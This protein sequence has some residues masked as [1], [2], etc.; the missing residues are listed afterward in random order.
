MSDLHA[1]W[2]DVLGKSATMVDHHA[3]LDVDATT[4]DRIIDGAH[5]IRLPA[6]AEKLDPAVWAKESFNMA[7]RDTY[8]IKPFV[9]QNS[10]GD[11]ILKI[12][13]TEDYHTTAVKDA[14]RR[15]RIA[16]HRLAL[17]LK[18]IL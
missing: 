2:D 1:Y 16:G 14:Q 8:S 7:K 6:S 13:L 3:R 15:I 5:K 4:A 12:T 9:A 18:Q 11:E 10:N 17:L